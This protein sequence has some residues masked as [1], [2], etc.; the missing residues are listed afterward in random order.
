MLLNGE[1]KTFEGIREQAKTLVKQKRYK[2]LF[3][4]IENSNLENKEEFL[5]I[6]IKDSI[7]EGN[8]LSA[9]HI[10][11][12]KGDY[13]K[14]IELY[15]K[16]YNYEDIFRIISKVEYNKKYKY[17]YY[18]LIDIKIKEKNNEALVQLIN[19]TGDFREVINRFIALKKINE[20]EKI[21][22]YIP[23]E[24]LIKEIYSISIK[25]L[26]LEKDYLNA[27][28][29]AK[30][31]GDIKTAFKLY[32]KAGREDLASFFQDQ[33]REY[34][35][36]MVRYLKQNKIEK[37]IDLA[38]KINNPNLINNFLENS[39]IN[40]GL[41]K[42]IKE[43]ISDRIGQR[44]QK[45]RTYKKFSTNLEKNSSGI[46]SQE[47]EIEKLP[48]DDE[49]NN[50]KYGKI[51]FEYLKDGRIEEARTIRKKIADENIVKKYYN[52]LIDE[53]LK[54][55]EYGKAIKLAGEINE[56]ERIVVYY[57]KMG[58]FQAA[59]KLS[60]ELLQSE[61][62]IEYYEK[63]KDCPSAIKLTEEIRHTG[64]I[65]RVERKY[66]DYLVDDGMTMQAGKIAEDKKDYYKAIELYD[67]C[68]S[69][70]DIFR[71]IN[72]VEYSE[73][74]K[75]IYGRLIY[76][77]IQ[78]RD[79]DSAAQLIEITG[80]LEG[81]VTR[82][83]K[84]K[85]LKKIFKIAD[86][87]SDESKIKEIYNI[88]LNQLLLEEDFLNAAEVSRRMGDLE[89]AIQL[90]KKAGREDISNFYYENIKLHKYTFKTYL[91][92]GKIEMAKKSLEK[93]E[94]KNTILNTVKNEIF[95]SI[96]YNQFETAKTFCKELGFTHL[97]P[98]I[99]KEIIGKYVSEN[100]YD[101]A[102]K[103]AKEFQNE[104]VLL[105]L[106]ERSMRYESAI[107]L[108]QKSGNREEFSR[109]CKLLID[110]NLRSANF[111]DLK[112]F[113]SKY[114]CADAIKSNAYAL[115]EQVERE[116]DIKSAIKLSEFLNEKEKL[117]ELYLKSI[118]SKMRLGYIENAKKM[119]KNNDFEN[120][121]DYFIK[122]E[123]YKSAYELAEKT[124]NEK[125]LELL[126]NLD[127]N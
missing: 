98:S 30:K 35:R 27:G 61:K 83:I 95:Q 20:I 99:S 9:G 93:I 80:D 78:K 5:N 52:N 63:A 51:L 55:E 19:I 12:I 14:A 91:K 10:A 67:K 44:N 41:I 117:D 79:Y 26:I 103:I 84:F 16:C 53:Y 65:N 97:L 7:N 121:I 37:A 74:Y 56:L 38:M 29:Y 24:N 70:E 21:A 75:D 64:E 49:I 106:Y 73:K 108:A 110:K 43:R 119:L 116:G 100:N 2:E 87:I 69:Y 92:Q 8:F 66:L 60:Y 25:L 114:D 33:I 62:N 112:K 96:I 104:D 105:D 39:G 68:S 47:V 50:L 28:H 123:D 32:K 88:S 115:L 17:I 113:E 120:A 46:L 11:E 4:T 124:N 86:N 77:K 122:G 107:E 90:Y 18:R 6:L 127:A 101:E 15:D 36:D 45:N 34:E 89:R 72:K 76:I 40:P 94:D 118:E 22:K 125:A 111:E 23:N 13:E 42:I 102:I 54:K 58:N 1:D 126:K 82:C 57:S 81:F 85:K 71:I 3:K 48:S 59:S 31:M 109:L